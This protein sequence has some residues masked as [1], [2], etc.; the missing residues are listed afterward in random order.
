MAPIPLRA[1]LVLRAPFVAQAPLLATPIISSKRQIYER[2]YGSGAAGTSSVEEPT[3]P[4]RKIRVAATKRPKR[5]VAADPA[6]EQ[7]DDGRPH[8]P[9]LLEEIRDAFRDVRYARSGDK[10]SKRE[11]PSECR[12]SRRTGSAFTSMGH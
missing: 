1:S 11:S 3:R 4:H 9:V 12:W 2:I 6:Q 7:A 10:C 5:E 8:I